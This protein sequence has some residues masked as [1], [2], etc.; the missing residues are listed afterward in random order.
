MERSRRYFLYFRPGS[1]PLEERQVNDFAFMVH[2]SDRV[3]LSVQVQIFSD[4][5]CSRGCH[6]G[7]YHRERE[8]LEDAIAK[9]GLTFVEQ[10]I[11]YYTRLF[12]DDIKRNPTTVE[13][14]DIAQ[15]NSE[16]SP[17]LVF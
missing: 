10:E 15:S 13:L 8:A 11:Q 4:Q 2:D 6:C 7:S 14:F 9:M 3:R 1:N 12:N 16:H 5:Y 17:A